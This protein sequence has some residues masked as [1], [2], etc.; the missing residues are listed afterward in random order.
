M[1]H[2]STY[3]INISGVNVNGKQIK[4]NDNTLELSIIKDMEIFLIHSCKQGRKSTCC[5]PFSD[6]QYANLVGKEFSGSLSIFLKHAIEINFSYILN[7][8][9]VN[10]SIEFTFENLEVRTFYK[11]SE[12]F[13]IHFQKEFE[14]PIAENV[15]YSD[16]KDF[17]VLFLGSVFDKSD[18]KSLKVKGTKNIDRSWFNDYSIEYG[19]K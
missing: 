14:E 15:N 9:P 12:A 6:I 7:E 8:P 3:S 19:L 10:G 13:L 16:E 11:F 5:I 2:M 17:D 18:N 1:N 4:F